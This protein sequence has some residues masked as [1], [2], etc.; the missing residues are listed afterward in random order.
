MHVLTF[1]N[2]VFKSNYRK[3][4]AYFIKNPPKKI[5]LLKNYYRNI[6]NSWANRLVEIFLLLSNDEAGK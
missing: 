3:L 6:W 4:L 1:K 2:K 5:R